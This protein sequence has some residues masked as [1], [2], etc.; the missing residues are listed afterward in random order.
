VKRQDNYRLNIKLETDEIQ[1]DADYYGRQVPMTGHGPK[2]ERNLQ[3]RFPPGVKRRITTLAEEFIP[4]STENYF[5]PN[6][7]AE[8]FSSEQSDPDKV[9]E[10]LSINESCI[11]LDMH[12]RI[13]VWYLPKVLSYEM[14]V[15]TKL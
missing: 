6:L 4:N 13:L 1:W 9:P 3:L 2:K 15:S 12:G 14:Q 10:Y 7:G 5:G 8:T 11:I